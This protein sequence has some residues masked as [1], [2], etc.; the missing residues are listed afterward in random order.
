M[1]NKTILFTPQRQKRP[2]ILLEVLIALALISLFAIPLVR[3]PLETIH[4]E[5]KSLCN[6]ELERNASLAFAE[7]KELFYTQ[8]IPWDSLSEKKPLVH[9]LGTQTIGTRTFEKTAHIHVSKEKVIRGGQTMR[10]LGVTLTFASPGLKQDF[11]Y[12]MVVAR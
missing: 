11:A 12:I 1:K 9:P 3:A 5:T 10:K 2:F 6:L 4:E 7:V 8:S